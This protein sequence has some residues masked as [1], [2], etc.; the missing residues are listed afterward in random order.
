[1][2]ECRHDNMS[3]DRCRNKLSAGTLG[4]ASLQAKLEEV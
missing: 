1:M 3:V 2:E 4:E